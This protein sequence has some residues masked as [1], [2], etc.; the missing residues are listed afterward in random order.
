MSRSSLTSM[1]NINDQNT[2]NDKDH[3][4]FR[5]KKVHLSF[6]FRRMLLLPNVDWYF[7]LTFVALLLSCSFTFTV[8]FILFLCTRDLRRRL[9]VIDSANFVSIHYYNKRLNHMNHVFDFVK[10]NGKSMEIDFPSGRFKLATVYISFMKV[11]K[12]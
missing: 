2:D 3:R 7:C 5:Y 11:H 4:I 1:F 6:S 9:N 12:E 8:D 10:V